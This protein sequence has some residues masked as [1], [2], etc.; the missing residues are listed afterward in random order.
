MKI[1]IPSH[2]SDAELVAKVTSLARCEREATAHLVAHL[3]E[4][5]A[6]K[7]HLGAGFS[8]LFTYCC[9][10]LGLSEHEAYN[11]IEAARA[12]GRFPVIL[13]MLL[14]GGLRSEERRVGKECPQLC[15][16]RWSPYH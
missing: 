5:D 4:F 16:S 9:E 1:S 11:R 12:A 13:D 6:R 10:I 8:S 7:L 15:R 14:E 3:V 2:L